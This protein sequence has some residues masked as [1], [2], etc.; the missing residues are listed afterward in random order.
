M[1]LKTCERCKQTFEPMSGAAKRCP[2]CR[3]ELEHERR[4]RRYEIEREDV[5]RHY[6]EHREEKLEYARRYRETHREQIKASNAR[7]RAAHCE[8]IREYDRLR[9]RK[10]ALIRREAQREQNL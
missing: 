1:K 9:K 6:L 3:K 2:T 4:R 7:Y 5:R 8:Q 10:Q